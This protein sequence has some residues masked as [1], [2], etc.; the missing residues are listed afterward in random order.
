MC[1][2]PESARILYPGMGKTLEVMTD[3]FV[4]QCKYMKYCENKCR[5][6]NPDDRIYRVDRQVNFDMMKKTGKNFLR[7]LQQPD[8][9]IWSI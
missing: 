6:Q 1:G 4:A 2:K 3:I 7:L 9:V 5:V 8:P